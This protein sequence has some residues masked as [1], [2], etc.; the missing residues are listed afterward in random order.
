[1]KFELADRRVVVFDESEVDLHVL[2]YVEIRERLGDADSV[3][4]VGELG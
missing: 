1:M 2:A 4:L 3:R